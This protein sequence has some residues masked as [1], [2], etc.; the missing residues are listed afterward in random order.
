MLATLERIQ[1]LEYAES[2]AKKIL[3]SDV[4]TE[5]LK[6]KIDLEQDKEAQAL[7]RNF[8]HMKEQYED[9]QRFGTYHPDYKKI[10]K[11]VRLIKRELDLNTTVY[12]FKQAENNLQKVLDDI[13]QVVGT[14]VSQYIKVPNGNPFFSQGCG[15]GS[16]G[17]CGCG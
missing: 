1:I 3:E 4:A 9:V 14:T 8:S 13:S 2:L 12:A 6:C 11:D 15:C 17:A 7:I 10:T 5:Y 16:G